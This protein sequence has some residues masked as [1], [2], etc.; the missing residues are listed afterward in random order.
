MLN[1]NQQTNRLLINY[2]LLIL[3]LIIPLPEAGDGVNTSFNELRLAYKIGTGHTIQG[4]TYF[5]KF[6][7]VWTFAYSILFL[8]NQSV[9]QIM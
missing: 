9:H 2:C 4:T 1:L 8:K 7:V 6:L 5:T 3:L